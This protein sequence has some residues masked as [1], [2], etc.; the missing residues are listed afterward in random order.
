M[1]TWQVDVSCF[2]ICLILLSKSTLL[3]QEASVGFLTNSTEKKVKIG[4]RSWRMTSALSVKT[5]M[6]MLFTLR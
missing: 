1:S 2:A 6:A 4:L 5:N 3:V